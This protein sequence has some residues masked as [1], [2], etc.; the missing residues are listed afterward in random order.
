MF[1]HKDDLEAQEYLSLF[2][3]SFQTLYYKDDFI[4]KIGFEFFP[5]FFMLD[6]EGI[7]KIF[8]PHEQKFLWEL[9]EH[10]IIPDIN[11]I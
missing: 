8:T 9:K 4:K 2:Q 7:F 10:G 3:Q 11:K 5:V 6:Q 1:L